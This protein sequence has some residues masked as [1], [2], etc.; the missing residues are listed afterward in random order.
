[1]SALEVKKNTARKRL[2]PAPGTPLDAA[3]VPPTR[4]AILWLRAPDAKPGARVI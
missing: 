1:M 2:D 3:S 4:L